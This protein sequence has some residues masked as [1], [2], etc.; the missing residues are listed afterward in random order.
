M[1]QEGS[2]SVPP[3]DIPRSPTGRIPKWVIDQTQGRVADPEPWRSHSTAQYESLRR[4]ERKHRSKRYLPIL[5]L[6]SIIGASIWLKTGFPNNPSL[7]RAIGGGIVTVKPNLPTPG[8]EESAHPLGSP[9]PLLATS[10]S[11]RFI[12]YQSD[13]VTPVAYDP[14]RPIHYVTRAQGEPVGGDQIISDAIIRVSQAT[15]LQFINDGKSFETP[16]FQRDVYQPNNYGDRWAPVLLAWVTVAENPDF[17]TNIEGKSGSVAM[18]GNDG[19][20][21][22]VSGIVELDSLKLTQMLQVPSGIEQVRAVVLHE[23]G[24]LVGLAH[25]ADANQLMYP[26]TGHGITDFATG[27]LTGAAI[28]GRGSC[29]PHL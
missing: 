23:L 25:I 3:D 20:K 29:A 6:I 17:A 18:V 4:I 26:E 14:C 7:K 2:G 16:T 22:Y 28:L 12:S 10:T 8:R 5:V 24:H 15:G 11:Y 13:L 19:L 1:K 21:T 9:E 27:D